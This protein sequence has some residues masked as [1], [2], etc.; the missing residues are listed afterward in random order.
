MDAISVFAPKA[1]LRSTAKSHP[2]GIGCNGL[3]NIIYRYIYFVWLFEA[4]FPR[5]AAELHFRIFFIFSGRYWM[6]LEY[7]LYERAPP[8]VF[9][10]ALA[11]TGYTRISLPQIH[12]R[13]KSSESIL[14]VLECLNG[15]LVASCGSNYRFRRL[16]APMPCGAGSSKRYDIKVAGQHYK[17]L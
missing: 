11:L 9:W 17:S 7:F 6:I 3:Y 10:G 2:P 13:A 16:G 15:H 4:R 5:T 14:V 1:H 12:F 8:V